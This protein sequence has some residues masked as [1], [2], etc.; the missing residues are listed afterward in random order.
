MAKTI[1]GFFRTQEDG[2]LAKAA[3]DQAGFTDD[4]VS[5]LAGDT[6]G[7]QTP[8]VGPAL[9]DEG[10]ESEAGSDAFVG[11]VIGL[12]AGVLALAIPGVGPFLAAGPL[13]AA[14]GGMTVGAAAGGVIGLLKDH[15]ISEEEAQFYAEGVSRGGS[16]LVVHGLSEESEKR[17][18]KILK[19]AGALSTEELADEWRASK[20]SSAGQVL[21][22][23]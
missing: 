4:Q 10:T 3:L 18:Q 15:G 2:V 9:Q 17:A 14:I 22:A 8:S 13:A 12:A 21:R 19:D 23:R 6:R 1:A 5:F 20:A 7:H 11:G 16:L